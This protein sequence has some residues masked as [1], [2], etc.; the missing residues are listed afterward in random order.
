MK[1]KTNTACVD[2]IEKLTVLHDELERLP[3]EVIKNVIL[4]TIAAMKTM[5]E[6]I[7]I[8]D[9]MMLEDIEPEGSA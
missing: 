4:E 1:L 8:R 9:E 3:P 2:I 5:R 6:L 7:G